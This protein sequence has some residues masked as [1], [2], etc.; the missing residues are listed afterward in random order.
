MLII[1]RKNE[2]LFDM[3]WRNAL[4]Q[5]AIQQNPEK[6]PNSIRFAHDETSLTIFDAYP[7]SL[8]HFLV[9]LRPTSSLPIQALDDL[10]SLLNHDKSQAKTVLE[11]LKVTAD[12]IRKQIE[13]EMI[14]RYGFKWEIWTGFHA[15]PSMLSV[16]PLVDSSKSTSCLADIFI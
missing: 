12:G 7:K 8:F 5:F 6:I 13:D 9:L 16:L 10:R 11:D 4:R 15:V 1:R 14:K 2:R 3:S